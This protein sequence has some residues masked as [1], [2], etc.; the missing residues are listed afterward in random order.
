MLKLGAIL[1]PLQLILLGLVGFGL[2][3][4]AALGLLGESGNQIVST[5]LYASVGLF[6]VTIGLLTLGPILNALRQM[7]R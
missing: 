6:A 4:A 5:I 2:A 3:F 7:N 1:I